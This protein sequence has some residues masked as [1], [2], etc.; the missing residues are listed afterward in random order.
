MPEVRLASG[1]ATVLAVVSVTSNVPPIETSIAPRVPG[2]PAVVEIETL[3]SSESWSISTSRLSS[4]SF[5][6]SPAS[7]AALI[8]PVSAPI[9]VPIELIWL[10]V[11]V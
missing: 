6:C 11:S 2:V 4:R 8:E 9:C 10:T 3:P 5:G 7:S 1:S